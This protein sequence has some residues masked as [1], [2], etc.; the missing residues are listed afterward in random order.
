MR[1]ENKLED[2]RA[3]ESKERS[4]RCMGKVTSTCRLIKLYDKAPPE[5]YPG[6]A[7]DFHRPAYLRQRY[8]ISF[9]LSSARASFSFPYVHAKNFLNM[10]ITASLVKCDRRQNGNTIL[11]GRDKVQDK[12]DGINWKAAVNRCATFSLDG[13]MTILRKTEKNPG[14]SLLKANNEN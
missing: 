7:V 1:K 8:E 13:K 12:T 2:G 9:H 10:F 14:K 5:V 3:R 4:W 11:P 6:R